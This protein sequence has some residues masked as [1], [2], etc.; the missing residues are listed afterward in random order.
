MT[1]PPLGAARPP[2]A[3]ARGLAAACAGAAVASRPPIPRAVALA[4]PRHLGSILARAADPLTP[5]GDPPRLPIRAEINVVKAS[6][7]YTTYEG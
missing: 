7:T 6:R 4:W 2:Q 1:Y 5:L 3:P